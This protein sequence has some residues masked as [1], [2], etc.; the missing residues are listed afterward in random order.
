M[1]KNSASGVFLRKN[2]TSPTG[3]AAANELRAEI[4]DAPKLD[5]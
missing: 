5:G 1:G 2:S 3:F 4:R